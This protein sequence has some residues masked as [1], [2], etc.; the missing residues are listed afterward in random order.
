MAQTTPGVSFGPVLIISVLPVAYFV[1]YSR[2]YYKI[3]ASIEK[4]EENKKT[5]YLWPQTMPNG[6]RGI[7]WARSHHLH[8]PS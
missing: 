7:V 8:P 3:L 5:T 2:R 4:N 6:A 1:D